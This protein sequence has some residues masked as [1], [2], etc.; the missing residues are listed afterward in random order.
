MQLPF[1]IS[2]LDRWRLALSR[3]STKRSETLASQPFFKLCR[4]I[5]HRR[6]TLAVS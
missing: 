5:F 2:G 4:H 3:A 6:A 1:S